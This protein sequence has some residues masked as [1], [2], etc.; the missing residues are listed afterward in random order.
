MQNPQRIPRIIL[1]GKKVVMGKWHNTLTDGCLGPLRS[2]TQFSVCL[3][4][5]V[6]FASFLYFFRMEL[7][8]VIAIIRHGDRTPKQKMKME[9]RHPLWV[10]QTKPWVVFLLPCSYNLMLT[11][12]WSTKIYNKVL[13]MWKNKQDKGK[14]LCTGYIPHPIIYSW[15][16]PYIHNLTWKK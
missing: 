3:K 1:K 2:H 7:R 4:S 13:Y 12:R 10:A 16:C 6:C 5:L 8:C 11:L 15:A 9:V 14:H